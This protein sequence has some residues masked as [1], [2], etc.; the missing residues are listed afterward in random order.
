MNRTI[1]D[2]RVKPFHDDGH[3]QLRTHLADFL[4]A[5]NFAGRLNTLGGLTPYEYIR[6][7]RMSEPDRFIFDFSDC[8]AEGGEAVQ[9]GYPDLELRHLTVEVSRH[10]AL[11]RQ[12]RLADLRF[13][14]CI[15][16]STRLGR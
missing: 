9:A 8:Y 10:E 15:L 2:V 11:A 16:V 4:A 6:K 3:T 5:Y 12:F 1:K 14:Q 13:T 7:I